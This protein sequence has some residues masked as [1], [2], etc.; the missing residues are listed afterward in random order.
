[1]ID[2]FLFFKSIRQTSFVLPRASCFSR[3]ISSTNPSINYII[4]A[5]NLTLVAMV[6]NSTR[7]SVILIGS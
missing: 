3:T 4:G 1:M 2:Q 5:F 6:M 7:E